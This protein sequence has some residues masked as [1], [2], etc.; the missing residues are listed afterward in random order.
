MHAYRSHTCGD[1]KAA[2]A[3]TTVRLSGW[4]HRVRDHGGVLFVDLRDHYG[5]TQVLA[6][7]DSPAFAAM[8]RLRAETVIRIDGRVKLRDASLVNPK[9]PTGEI[10]VYA[11]EIEVSGPDTS[12]EVEY[13]LVQR[14]DGLWV[15]V[16]SD[17]TDRKAETVGVS[18]SKQLCAKVA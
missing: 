1:L 5:M 16:G 14:P 15:T 6:D 12:G 8:D 4:V 11:T 3:G 18:L 2:D 17:H 7:S 9:L 10:E 13:V